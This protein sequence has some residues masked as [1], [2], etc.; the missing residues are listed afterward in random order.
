[1][2]STDICGIYEHGADLFEAKMHF[3]RKG[4]MAQVGQ[5]GKGSSMARYSPFFI[6]HA[7]H[8]IDA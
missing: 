5:H 7:Y 4:N 2:H 6:L 1:M 8:R 3:E